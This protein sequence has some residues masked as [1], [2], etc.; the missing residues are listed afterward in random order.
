MM[1]YKLENYEEQLNHQVIHMDQAVCYCPEFRATKM[2]HDYPS[3]RLQLARAV[4]KNE[5]AVSDYI[6]E[7]NFAGILSR[8]G[9]RWQNFGEL[10]EDCTDVTILSRQMLLEKGYV[11][12]A[13]EEF[14]AALKK[15]GGR[16]LPQKKWELPVDKNSQMAILLDD[17]TAYCDGGN[18]NGKN[19]RCLA[20]YLKMHGMSFVN[21]AE[22][23]FLGFEYFAYGLVEEGAAHLKALIEKYEAMG[24]EKVLV[25]SAKAA[26]LLTKFAEKLDRRPV[27]EVVYLPDI[28]ETIH[29]EEKT[30]VY[31]GSFNLR[32]LVNGNSLNE[33]IPA[34]SEKQLPTSQEFT[35]LLEGN[36]RINQLTIWQK[37]IG[38]EYQLFHADKSMLQ[39]IEDDACQDIKNAGADKILVMEPTAYQVLKERFRDKKVVYYLEEI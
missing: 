19:E 30:Y 1:N 3:R 13:A 39:A 12:P 15:G 7:I 18:E 32:Y 17:E 31:A 10:E 36:A 21:E 16:L 35:P 29:E 11:S 14:K 24:A 26:Y 23:E 6:G 20:N 25:L 37:P 38:A 33:L 2:M 22:S 5:M 28:L 4:F 9:E 27:F 34:D 8:Q